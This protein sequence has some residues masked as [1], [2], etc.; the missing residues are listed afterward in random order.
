[1][2]TTVPTSLAGVAAMLRYA[3]E[4]EDSGSEWPGTDTIGRE[5]WHYQLRQSAAR[6]LEGLLS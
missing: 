2:A 4:F 6:A 5:G 3:N 1:M